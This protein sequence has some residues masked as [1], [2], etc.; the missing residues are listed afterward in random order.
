M[1]MWK[2]SGVHPDTAVIGMGRTGCS[3]VRFLEQQGIVCA[4][5]DEK[6]KALPED[7]RANLHTGTLRPKDLQGYSRVIVSPGVDWRHPALAHA[8]AQGV[9]VIGDIDLFNERFSGDL[10]AITGTNGKS[11]VVHLVGLMLE[12][13][14]GGVEVGGN[15]G[16]P[17]L[18]MLH[19]GKSP[20]RAVLELSSFQ[21]ERCQGIHPKWAVLLNVQPDHADM[22]ENFDDYEAA[23]LRL[24]EQQGEGDIAM[25]PLDVHWTDLASDL[26]QRGVRVRHFSIMKSGIMEH[27]RQ[28][29]AGLLPEEGESL[30]D[31][32][33]KLF[34]TEGDTRHEIPI[35]RLRVRGAYQQLNLAV[36]AQA[37]ADFGVSA[38]VITESLTAFRGLAHRLQYI[39]H[40][41]G[42]AWYDDSKATNP[43]AAKAA[44]ISFERAIWICGGLT[45]G[46][47]LAPMTETVKQHVASAYI[48][49]KQ[50]KPY[51]EM[52]KKAGVSCRVAGNMQKAVAL[53]AEN[54]LS[55]PVLLSP[56]AASQDQFRDY[57]ERGDRFA[58]AV[59]Q[60]EKAA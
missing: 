58:E 15:I 24:F 23:K 43:D 31:G 39:G 37:A 30:E 47:D 8:R 3:V 44:L 5:Y 57:A 12:V 48:I 42:R 53:A 50:V 45:K 33:G 19:D 34:W 26:A 40:R 28:V 60:L 18:D 11:T 20:A 35:E 59:A 49:G 38:N 6:L 9:Q 17:M 22:H 1:M 7:I 55:L 2:K 25:L 14:H 56:A 16:V 32:G 10:L 13:L 4:A 29:D 21:L 54:K 36:A 51:R 27:E 52:L 41:M 46:L